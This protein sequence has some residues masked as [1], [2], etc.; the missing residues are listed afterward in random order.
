MI[1][2]RS[3]VLGV[4]RATIGTWRKRFAVRRLAGL[5]DD[6]RTGAPRRISDADVEHA[7]ATTLEQ[8][9]RDATHWRREGWR[10]R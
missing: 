4:H 9:P 8:M 2:I 7:I 1:H 10:R 3:S 5:K 6:P